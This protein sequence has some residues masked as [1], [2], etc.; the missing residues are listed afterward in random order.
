MSPTTGR[1]VPG[2]EEYERLRPRLLAILGQLRWSG[3]PIDMSMAL[4]LVHDFFVEVWPGLRSRFDANRGAWDSYVA[5][6]FVRFARRRIAVD[7]RWRAM[8]RD[9]VP[10]ELSAGPDLDLDRLRGALESLP[11]GDRRLLLDRFEGETERGLAQKRGWSRYAVRERLVRALAQVASVFGNAAPPGSVDG[12]VARLLFEEG[13]SVPAV[14][15]LLKLTMAQVH[16]ARARVLAVMRR[17][18]KG[19]MS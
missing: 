2:P 3:Y 18:A 13:R 19:E 8:L 17:Y 7:S 12:R 11:A 4:D 9:V 6:A 10:T 5:G 1:V 16:A 15:A 14:A